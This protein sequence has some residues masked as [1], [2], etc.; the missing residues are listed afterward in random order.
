MVVISGR[1]LVQGPPI[2]QC[3]LCTRR[4]RFDGH[5]VGGV[6]GFH[7]FH[8]LDSIAYITPFD[9]TLAPAG[10]PTTPTY[11]C[12]HNLVFFGVFFGIVYGFIAG[13]T[14]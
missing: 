10:D 5:I 14:L 9:V 11:C 4:F 8:Y 7:S 13:G 12:W 6:Y 1:G 3:F 2:C